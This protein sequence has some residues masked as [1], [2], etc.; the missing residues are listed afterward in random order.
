VV[1]TLDVDLN[2][3]IANGNDSVLALATDR[4]AWRLDLATGA[5]GQIL[6]YVSSW[7]QVGRD[8]KC[9]VAARD[10]AIVIADLVGH[11]W[12]TIP[13]GDVFIAAPGPTCDQI[14]AATSHALL[15]EWDVAL[16]YTGARAARLDRSADQRARVGQPR[17]D[18]VGLASELTAGS[19]CVAR[20]LVH[21]T[22]SDAVRSSQPRAAVVAGQPVVGLYGAIALLG[23]MLSSGRGDP[24]VYRLAD[25]PTWVLL[26]S[27][28]LGLVVGLGVVGLSRIAVARWEWA[29]ALHAA[30]RDILG[31]LT[32]REVIVL[33]A[34]ARSARSCC[35]AARCCRGSAWSRRRSRSAC[36]TSGRASGSCRG[37]CPR[38]QWASRSARWRRSPATSARRSSRTS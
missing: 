23:L 36:S 32:G 12:W 16:P 1:A 21:S 13:S 15:A 31:P 20:G 30:F 5:V 37:R 7:P 18:R 10:G 9:A 14:F 3:L 29:R 2:S 8:G 4:S 19:G 27:P 33:A 35:S 22:A 17:C 6:P 11:A 34:R 38:A 24:D 28:L 26:V 25:R